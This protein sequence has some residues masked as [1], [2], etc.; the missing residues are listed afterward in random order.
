MF[1][2][3]GSSSVS[4]SMHPHVMLA[5][6]IFFAGLAIGCAS[7]RP[8]LPSATGGV[9]DLRSWDFQRD[10]AVRLKGDWDFFPR[11]L[12]RGEAG[13]LAPRSGERRV[14]DLWTDKTMGSARGIGAGT[15]R[16]TVLLPDRRPSLGIKYTTVSTAFE[17]DADALLVANGGRPALDSMRDLP[18][19]KPGVAILPQSAASLVLVVRASNY[20]YRVGGMWRPFYLGDIETLERRDWAGETGSLALASSLAVLAVLFAFFVRGGIEGRGF[21][22]F[23]I[24]SIMSGLRAIVTGE[25][26][27]VR[28]FPSLSFDL[29]I[30]LEYLCDYTIFPIGLLFFSSLFPED[31]DSRVTRALLSICVPF[32][33]LVPL[34]PLRALT[35]SIQAYYFLAAAIII[36]VGVITVRS[37]ARRRI[38]ALPLFLGAAAL[39]VA[40]I[41]EILFSSFIIDSGNFFSYGMIIFVGTQACALAGRHSWTQSQLRQALAAKEL[42]I[43]EVHHRVKNSLQI[44]SSIATLQSHRVEDPVVLA[45]YSSMQGRIRAI[46]LVHEKLYALDSAEVVDVG[47]YAQNL[48]GLLADGY[49][50]E[51]EE[52]LLVDSESVIVPA[53]LCIDLGIIMAELVANS[54]KYAF[55]PARSGKMRVRIRRTGPV[56]S[57][58]VEDDGPGF[59]EGSFVEAF[60]TLGFRLIASLAKKH[61]ASVSIGKGP[62]ATVELRFPIGEAHASKSRDG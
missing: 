6:I 51:G 37:V 27:I 57:L 20:E 26:A 3:L 32:L 55:G 23:C 21:I 25:Y 13:L 18:A 4:T 34:A 28:L 61:D 44:V 41:N 29:L 31:H 5:K 48:A 53:D 24:F 38:G 7:Q 56:L 14:P 43:R 60:P 40:A 36:A 17:L 47:A 15:Y 35:W 12:L 49:G 52:T 30:R 16:L 62:G 9:L 19:Y 59:A 33:A 54:Y 22:Y 58:V 10:G 8:P 11:V 46:G 2:S 45:A 42:L 39:A 50:I 1:R